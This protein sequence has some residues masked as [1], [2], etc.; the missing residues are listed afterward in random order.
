MDDSLMVASQMRDQFNGLDTKI[1]DI[2]ARPAGPM[3]PQGETGPQGDPAPQG[4]PFAS[5]VADAVNTGDPGSSA[6]V[7]VSFDGTYVHVTFDIPRGDTGAEVPPGGV[8]QG[9]LDAAIATT[10]LNPSGVGPYT[11]TFGDPTTQ[12]ELQD[13]AA[14][15]E[16][17]R[18]AVTRM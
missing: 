14:Y 9:Q 10:A 5:A 6:N 16:T 4:P 1:N 8:S 17:F 7:T 13:F 15:I 11:G 18:Q 3:G 2:P 12:A